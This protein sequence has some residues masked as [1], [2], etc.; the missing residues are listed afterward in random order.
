MAAFLGLL[1]LCPAVSKASEITV[2]D[3]RDA[4]TPPIASFIGENIDSAVSSGKTAIIIRMDTPGGLD[5][6]MRDIVQKEMNA[7]IP[8]IVY[9]YPP[10]ARAASAGAIIALASDVAAMAPGTNIGAAHPVGVGGV[11]GGEEAKEEAKTMAEKVTNDAVA[12]VRSIARERGRNEAWAQDA[13]VKSIS[14]PAHEALQLG[15]IDLVAQDMNDLLKGLD[16]RTVKKNNRT[17]V[18][19]TTGAK[20]TEV[21]MGFRY[22]LLAALSNP[23]IAY[24]L[25][26][27]GLAGIF[28]ELS[29]P[30]VILPGVIGG[31]SLILAFFAFQT[32]PVNYAGIA[33]ILLAVILFIAEIKVPSFGLLTVGGVISMLLGS[34]I[35]FRDEEIYA[36]VSLGVIVPVTLL[37]VAFFVATLSLVVKA[38]RRT[39]VTGAQG[40]VGEQG[41]VFTWG[42]EGRGKVFC[43]GEYWNAQGPAD[44]LPGDRVVVTELRGLELVVR[45]VGPSR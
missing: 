45:P 18:L 35:L 26:L 9:V 41:E 21:E 1:L 25:M 17:F 2:L 38:H 27:I 19:K 42:P 15:V 7:N 13:V 32:L 39:A 28:F 16:G 14:T 8:V 6:A 20:L 36:Q 43:H 37:F 30:G 3:I 44:L 4:I 11:G 5:T 12:Y 22:R 34:L 23:N 29:N 10:G 33:L 40:I 31:I 24:I